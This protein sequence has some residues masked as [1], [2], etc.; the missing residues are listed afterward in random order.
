MQHLTKLL[1]IALF[2]TSLFACKKDE[3]TPDPNITFKATLNGASEVPAT[4][5]T[6]TGSATLVYNSTTKMFTLTL[7]Y[8]GLTPTAGHIHKGA[9]GTNG[10]VVFPFSGLTNTFTYTSAALDATQEADLLANLYYVNLHTTAFAGGEI[11][12]QLIKQ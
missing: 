11:R 1:F 8:S 4:T 12:G 5:S 3:T 2:T 7:N 9:A 6:A 10:S